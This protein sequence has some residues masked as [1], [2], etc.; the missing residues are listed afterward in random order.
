MAGSVS[1]ASA[2][3]RQQPL[4]SGRAVQPIRYSE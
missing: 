1:T 3:H 2:G 4:Q